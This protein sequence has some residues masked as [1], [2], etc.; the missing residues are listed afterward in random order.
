MGTP[1]RKRHLCSGGAEWDPHVEES[2]YVSGLAW[3]LSCGVSQDCV[4]R[5]GRV[6][7][8]AFDALGPSGLHQGIFSGSSLLEPV[9]VE[10]ASKFRSIFQRHSGPG[11]SRFLNTG[12]GIDLPK[13]QVS[14]KRRISN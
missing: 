14:M 12:L 11:K 8:M 13:K 4:P 1:L 3:R 7:R 10:R 6:Y 5:C 2:P 9:L